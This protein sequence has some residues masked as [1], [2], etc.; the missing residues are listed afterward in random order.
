VFI[1]GSQEA[2]IEW[3]KMEQS[4]SRFVTPV[5]VGECVKKETISLEA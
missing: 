4:L 3:H 5:E 1:S 2:G